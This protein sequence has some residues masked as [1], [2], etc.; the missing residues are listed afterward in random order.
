MT[1][2]TMDRT[3]APKNLWLLCLVYC[4]YIL[5]RLS[6]KNLG[7]RTPIEACFGVTPEISAILCFMFYQKVYYSVNNVAFPNTK[8]AVG[9]FV[10][11]SENKG[12]A[13]TFQILIEDGE[14]VAIMGSSGSGKSTLLNILGILDTYDGG[15]YHLDQI[16]HDSEE[17]P[18][19]VPRC[20]DALLQLHILCGL[21]LHCNEKYDGSYHT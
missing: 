7:Y 9:R 19:H 17:I 12:D 21:C 3:G 10:G 15:E 18:L 11:I 16:W 13:L 1:T 14:F 2:V 20:K 6:H 5:N 4:V 8:E